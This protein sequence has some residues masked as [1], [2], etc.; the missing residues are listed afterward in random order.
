MLGLLCCQQVAPNR[1]SRR[2]FLT[3]GTLTV[4]ALVV[5]LWAGA[6]LVPTPTQPEP[7]RV[8]VGLWPG[9]EPL[10]LAREAGEL[11]PRRINLVEINWT[12]AAMRAVGNRV[13]D[14]AVMSLEEVILQIR[15]GYPLKV[16]MI[17]DISRGA[18][19]LMTNEKIQSIQDLK[20]TR[21]GYEPRTSGAW[22]LRKALQNANLKLTDVQPVPL[23]PSEVDEI[24]TELT[25]D[26]VVLAEPWGEKLEEM[27]LSK[28]YDSSHDGSAIVRVLAV[29]PE[30]VIEHRQEL[31]ELLRLHFRWNARLYEEG[32]HMEPVLRREGLKLDVFREV[33]SRLELVSLE[34]NR[35]LLSR[36]DPWLEA[37][38]LKQQGELSEGEPG[39]LP[40]RLSADAIFDAS[41]LNQLP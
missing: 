12:S 2:P 14:A 17:T 29:H 3:P 39:E 6:L 22:L 1:M 26:G 8:A 23:N 11:D 18:D 25:L 20:G 10:V 41:L 24:F 32:P 31:L 40:G 28:I 27:H 16:V 36:E 19:V 13:V 35:R 5:A 37:L 33:L 30:A 9:A 38:F 15:Q 34:K 4:L 7:L 21:I